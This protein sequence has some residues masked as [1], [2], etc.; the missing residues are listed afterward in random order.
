MS[1]GNAA[2]V[3]LM[4]MLIPLRSMIQ[5]PLTAVPALVSFLEPDHELRPLE[6]DLEDSTTRSADSEADERAGRET[7]QQNPS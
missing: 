5:H 3:D 4:L 2:K 7:L 1:A 6:P